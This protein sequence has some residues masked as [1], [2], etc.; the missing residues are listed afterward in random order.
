MKLLHSIEAKIESARIYEWIN[1]IKPEAI[2]F[3]LLSICYLSFAPNSNEEQY[4]QLAKQFVNP[5][6]IK[7]SSNLTEFAGTRVLYQY[8]VGSVLKFLSFEQTVFLFRL[9]FIILFTIPLAKIYRQVRL[10]NMYIVFHLGVLYL[11]QQSL[12]AGA[13]IFVTVEPKSFAYFCVLFG[14]Y[15]FIRGKYT[16]FILWSIAASY[17]HILVGFYATFF[18]MLTLLVKHKTLNISIKRLLILGSTYALATIPLILYLKGAIQAKVESVPSASWIYTYFRSPH[19]TAI[20]KDP[21]Y[22]Y[23][24]H[25]PGIVLAILGL[26]FTWRVRKNLASESLRSLNYF[27]MVSLLGTLLLVPIA[28][29]DKEGVILKYYLFRI[30]ALSTLGLTLIIASQIQWIANTTRLKIS[31]FIL[32]TSFASLFFLVFTNLWQMVDYR[33]PKQTQLKEICTYIKDNTEQNEVVLN[34]VEDVK[35]SRYTE[36]NIF[37]IYKFIPADFT[38]MYDWYERILVQNKIKS[39]HSELDGALQD[40]QIDYVLSER[41]LTNKNNVQL[42]QQNEH[43][44]LYK[45]L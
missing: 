6:W 16:P 8:M 38:K 29:L 40:Y 17:F 27:V 35:I 15:Y 25:F 10:S 36:R 4:M 19:H 26:Y 1:Q 41:K 24:N 43:F 30:N 45:R 14:F 44:Y 20:F 2:I 5:D 42:I 22:F 39:D 21:S 31:D 9:L 3:F 7:D 33:G 12:F 37:V 23:Q 28:F 34:L 13:W 18:L 11:T 32:L